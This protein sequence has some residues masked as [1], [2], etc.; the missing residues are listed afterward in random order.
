MDG[1]HALGARLTTRAGSLTRLVQVQVA[2]S[3]CST[4]DPVVH[5]GLGTAQQVDAVQVSWLDGTA[6]EFGPFA[7]G[8]T[9]VVRRGAGRPVQR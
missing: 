3:F 5:V 1:R 9:H 8:A 2:S 7:A 4:N 6:E